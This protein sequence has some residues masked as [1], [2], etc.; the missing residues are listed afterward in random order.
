MLGVATATHATIHNYVLTLDGLQETPPNAS[1][2]SGFGTADIDDV[3]NT[4][5]LYVVFSGLTGPETAAHIHGMA[6]PGTAAGVLF[7]LPLGSPKS[8]VWSYM[9]SQEADIL[10]GLTYVNIHTTTFPGGEIRGQIVPV[11]E[12][13][14]SALAVMGAGLGFLIRRKQQAR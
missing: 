7:A 4:L 11:P 13:A 12:P 2:A 10:A 5:T 14:P 6:P 1:P 8:A 3:A 9:E